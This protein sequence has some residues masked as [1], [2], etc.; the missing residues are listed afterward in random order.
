ME[1]SLRMKTESWL[2][3]DFL[4]ILENPKYEM[5]TRDADFVIKIIEATLCIVKGP[6]KE[7]L[8]PGTVAEIYLLQSGRILL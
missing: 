4:E 6:K 5:R 3:R 8:S 7:N 2:L 1:L